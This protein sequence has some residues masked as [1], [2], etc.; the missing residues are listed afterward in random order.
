VVVARRTPR[1]AHGCDRA[2]R[3]LYLDPQLMVGGAETVQPTIATTNGENPRTPLT[4]ASMKRSLKPA[5]RCKTPNHRTSTPV[6]AS[7]IREFLLRPGHRSAHYLLRRRGSGRGEEGRRDRHRRR[8]AIRKV[9]PWPARPRTC[10][11]AALALPRPRA[12]KRV[13]RA[14]STQSAQ[15]LGLLLPSARELWSVLPATLYHVPT[16]PEE[17]IRSK[18]IQV[19][20]RA[21]PVW[22]RRFQ[23]DVELP[24]Q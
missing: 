11:A 16:L 10:A 6:V 5:G 19:A 17:V 22:K 24:V 18:A 7:P 3:R 4:N 1:W 15:P 20:V 23:P 21:C 9:P 2:D 13:S 14:C 8:G 12:P